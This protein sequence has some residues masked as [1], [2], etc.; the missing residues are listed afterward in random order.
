MERQ[1][2]GERELHRLKWVQNSAVESILP[3]HPCPSLR[4]QVKAALIFVFQKRSASNSQSQKSEYSTELVK[5][6]GVNFSSQQQPLLTP[7]LT[8]SR[9]VSQEG[10]TRQ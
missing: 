7:S 6:V 2:R 5:L 4:R 3:C 1:K 10:E 9:R 8:A